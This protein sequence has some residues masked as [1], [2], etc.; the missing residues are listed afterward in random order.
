MIGVIGDEAGSYDSP[1]S[2]FNESIHQGLPVLATPFRDSTTA[3]WPC[4]CIG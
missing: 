4:K 2:T 3:T 1:S